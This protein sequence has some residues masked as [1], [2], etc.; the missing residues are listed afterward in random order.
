MSLQVRAGESWL[1]VLMYAP[2]K[3]LADLSS[4]GR[5]EL[6]H[7]ETLPAFAVLKRASVDMQRLL[8]RVKGEDATVSMYA[9]VNEVPDL[10]F[11]QMA[12]VELVLRPA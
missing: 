7:D 8:F 2:P 9:F 1:G 12:T 4:G 6:V 5:F 11:D 3:T 10:K